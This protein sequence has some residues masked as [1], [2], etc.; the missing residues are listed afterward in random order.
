MLGTTAEPQ[1][2][3]MKFAKQSI[4][5]GSIQSFEIL[6]SQALDDKFMRLRKAGITSE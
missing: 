3:L 4:F 2:K 5:Q 6:E 1:E